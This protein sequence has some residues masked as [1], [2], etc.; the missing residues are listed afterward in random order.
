MAVIIN[1]VA[2]PSPHENHLRVLVQGHSGVKGAISIQCYLTDNICQL[3]N[4]CM[5]SVFQFTETGLQK[6][7]KYTEVRF[8]MVR[9]LLIRFV[10]YFAKI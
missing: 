9:A 10:N 3:S 5:R 8:K 2:K 4:N 1:R 6:S 7:R